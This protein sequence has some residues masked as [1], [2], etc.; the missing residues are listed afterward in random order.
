MFERVL[1]T[2]KGVENFFDLFNEGQF[3]DFFRDWIKVF[4]QYWLKEKQVF[5]NPYLNKLFNS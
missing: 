2:G 5:V 4:Q 3:N 1:R